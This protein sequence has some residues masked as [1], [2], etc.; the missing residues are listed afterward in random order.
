MLN[1]CTYTSFMDPMSDRERVATEELIRD[2][3]KVSV[4][5]TGERVHMCSM[6]NPA[7]HSAGRIRSSL[8]NPKLQVT[9][10]KATNPAWPSHKKGDQRSPEITLGG[11]SVIKYLHGIVLSTIAL[12]LR[13]T[14][15]DY[16]NMAGNMETTIDNVVSTH[17]AVGNRFADIEAAFKSAPDGKTIDDGEV[18]F[19]LAKDEMRLACKAMQEF[20]IRLSFININEPAGAAKP[21]YMNQRK[22]Y[23]NQPSIQ[24]SVSRAPSARSTPIKSQ[25][26]GFAGD[27]SDEDASVQATTTSEAG[28]STAAPTPATPSTPKSASVTPHSKISRANSTY[29][30]TSR[31]SRPVGFATVDEDSDEDDAVLLSSA[32]GKAPLD[33]PSKPQL[34]RSSNSDSNNLDMTAAEIRDMEYV[35]SHIGDNDEDYDP[36]FLNILSEAVKSSRAQSPVAKK[37]LEIIRQHHNNS[38]LRTVKDALG[39]ESGIVDVSSPIVQW[40]MNEATM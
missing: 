1:V 34:N 30:V 31:N 24:G 10:H 12:G 6:G 14:F 5:M 17:T 8:S 37:V 7:Q 40:V 28:T 22:A 25:A 4:I 3:I 18:L 21:S 29:S 11:K 35:A 23:S 9:V 26:V 27:D 19:R 20:R 15:E 36:M 13:Y 39:I 16:D 2:L 32:K 38:K 33:T